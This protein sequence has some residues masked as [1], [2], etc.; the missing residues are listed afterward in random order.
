MWWC[1]VV[2]FWMNKFVPDPDATMPPK[3]V[4]ATLVL[5]STRVLTVSSI[6]ILYGIRGGM[7]QLVVGAWWAGEKWGP[8]VLLLD[9]EA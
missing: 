4:R 8:R 5:A 3:A 1:G 2:A 6:L 7:S 9:E